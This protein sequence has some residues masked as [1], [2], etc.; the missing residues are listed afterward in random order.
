MNMGGAIFSGCHGALN[1]LADEYKHQKEFLGELMDYCVQPHSLLDVL[2]D[3]YHH[4]IWG[5]IQQI[6]KSLSKLICNVFMSLA[7]TAGVERN[8]KI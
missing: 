1:L 2:K 7:S 6:Y 5:L 4:L 8:I 3:W